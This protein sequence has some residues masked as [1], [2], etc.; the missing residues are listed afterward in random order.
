MKRVAIN[1]YGRI[2]KNFLRAWLADARAQEE[3]HIVAINIGPDDPAGIGY[4]TRYDSMLGTYTGRVEYKDNFLYIDDYSIA[5][6]AEEDIL[7]IPW[8][9]HAIDWVVESS[10]KATQR[11]IAELHLHAGAHKVLI[12]APGKDDDCMVILGVNDQDYNSAQHTIISLGSCTTNAIIPLLYVLDK[13]FGVAEAMISTTHAYTNSQSLLDVH[14]Q[15]A[16]LRRSRA[17]ALNIV[18]STTGALGAIERVMPHLKKRISGNALRVP[19]PVVSM[20]EV[21]FVS[22]RTLTVSRLNDALSEAAQGEL[23]GI[24]AIS[25]EPLVSTDYARNSHS[26]IVDTLLTGVVGSLGKVYGWYDNEWGYSC[27]LKDF[28]AYRA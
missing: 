2:G 25:T 11:K 22:T 17:A 4:A 20:G 16:D 19:V 27:R 6:Y 21:T 24:M 12:T 15:E 28:L 10:G 9:A 5:V 13:N 7:H 26:V 23:A 1:G 14:A 18:P 8:S 3:F